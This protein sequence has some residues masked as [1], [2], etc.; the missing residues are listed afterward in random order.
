MKY[1]PDIHH[2]RSI[3]LKG[4][5]YTA[6]GYYF[7]TICTFQ[8]ECIL[9]E[10]VKGEMRLNEY[11]EIVKH[12]WE[13]IP[14]HFKQVELDY[15]VVM[16]NHVH[17]III[18]MGTVGGTDTGTANV[19]T[20][21][22]GAT[23]VGARH[24]S[25]LPPQHASPLPPQHASPLPPQHASPLPPQHASPL[26]PQQPP[27][28]PKGPESNSLGAIIGSFKSAVTKRINKLRNTPGQIVWQRNYYE[29]IIRNE[30]ELYQIRQYIIDNP[31]KWEL[32]RENSLNMNIEFPAK[33]KPIDQ[34]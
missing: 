23:H 14:N 21:D 15:N 12:C 11:G 13:E 25:P 2:R 24:A 28:R 32:D 30:K 29:R 22:A 8:W 26:P 18:Q 31:R 16:P 6:G 9:G 3:R 34:S 10:V 4:Y 33:E 1:N 5:D 27:T 20:T 19:G 17:G 7:V